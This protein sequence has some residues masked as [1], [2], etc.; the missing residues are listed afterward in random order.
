M[1]V[2]QGL[3]ELVLLEVQLPH[4]QRGEGH[5]GHGDIQGTTLE[6]VVTTE[7]LTRDREKG[8]GGGH[9]ARTEGYTHGKQVR[10]TGALMEWEGKKGELGNQQKEGNP[11]GSSG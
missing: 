8:G 4:V 10:Q 7:F 2:Q 9:E 11:K 5:L 3:V 6:S 1:G